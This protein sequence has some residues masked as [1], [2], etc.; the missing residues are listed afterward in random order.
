MVGLYINHHDE[1]MVYENKEPIHAQNQRYFKS[2]H[3]SEF[4]KEQQKT[5]DLLSESINRVICATDEQ[6][7]VQTKRWKEANHRLTELHSMIGNDRLVE[8][9]VLD[10]ILEQ[11]HRQEQLFEQIENKET[12]QEELLTRMK[13]QEALMEKVLRK[14]AN[15]RSILFERTSFLTDKIEDNY[16]LTTTLIYNLWSGSDPLPTFHMSRENEKKVD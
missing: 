8:K 2:G 5:S 10:K 11:I 13:Q 16:H 9:D 14:I 3:L 6:Q 12:I 1:Q 7:I 4:L 15:F